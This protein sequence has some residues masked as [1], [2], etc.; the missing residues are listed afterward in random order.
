MVVN[1]KKFWQFSAVYCVFVGILEI[2]TCAVCIS[3]GVED[4]RTVTYMILIAVICSFVE[5]I[6]LKDIYLEKDD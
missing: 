2:I 4:S 6:F 3:S 5:D 1:R